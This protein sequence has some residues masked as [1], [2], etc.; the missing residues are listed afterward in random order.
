MVTVANG[1]VAGGGAAVGSSQN[2]TPQVSWDTKIFNVRVYGWR[3]GWLAPPA[4][5][6][7]WQQKHDISAKKSKPTPR[8]FRRKTEEK[9]LVVET[10]WIKLFHKNTRHQNTGV[11]KLFYT[12]TF[13]L[14]T[15]YTFTRTSPPS[16]RKHLLPP[17]SQQK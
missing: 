11:I 17:Y 16:S 12:W 1:G 13:P 2:R 10:V 9:K 3:A 5:Q 7:P 4:W 6:S 15:F 8:N 14:P